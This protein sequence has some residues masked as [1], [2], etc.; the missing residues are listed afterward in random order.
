[1]SI[2][3][4]LFELASRAKFRFQTQRGN[5]ALED[6]WSLPLTEL[7]AIHR[8][9]GNQ[10]RALEEDTLLQVKEDKGLDTIKAKRE[11]VKHIV[12]TRQAENNEAK[13]RENKRIEAAR[14]RELIAQKKD[15]DLSGK[16]A[17]ELEALLRK[18]EA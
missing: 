10:I 9:L 18:L 5:L 4:N 8:E 12:V 2:Q 16:S 3:V 13:V 7:D 6:L 14:I 15:A 17:K 1:M 11:L